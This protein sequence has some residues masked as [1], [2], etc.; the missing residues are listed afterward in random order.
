MNVRSPLKIGN[1][2]YQL[3][4][5]ITCGGQGKVYTAINLEKEEYIVVKIIDLTKGSKWSYYTIETNAI[6]AVEP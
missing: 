3:K 1:N 5:E 2:E 4:S 6:L